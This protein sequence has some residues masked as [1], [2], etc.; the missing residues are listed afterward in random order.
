MQRI[1]RW[2]RS[3]S[4]RLEWLTHLGRS[5]IDSG[6]TQGR[7]HVTGHLIQQLASISQE[8]LCSF[9]LVS[10]EGCY[11]TEVSR[12]CSNGTDMMLMSRSTCKYLTANCN[13]AGMCAMASLA[14]LNF[15]GTLRGGYSVRLIHGSKKRLRDAQTNFST[16]LFTV[17][18]RYGDIL[19]ARTRR[20]ARIFL[21]LLIRRST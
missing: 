20:I 17:R 5:E 12:N 3:R 13:G 2:N 8:K 21:A 15:A 1:S 11:D 10:L 6:R 16:G 4:L 9:F 7:I 19:Q 18:E 14:K